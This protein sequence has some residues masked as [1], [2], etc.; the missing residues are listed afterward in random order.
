MSGLGGTPF[1][2]NVYE[3]EL[4]VFASFGTGGYHLWIDFKNSSDAYWGR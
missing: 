2:D 4:S 3:V 1:K